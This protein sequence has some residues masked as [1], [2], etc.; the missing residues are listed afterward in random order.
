MVNEPTQETPEGATI[1]VPK[2]GK[3]L[4]DMRKI[5]KADKPPS[6]ADGGGTE[7]QQPEG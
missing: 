1:P 4:R 3:V 6:D 5:A 7:E 2:R